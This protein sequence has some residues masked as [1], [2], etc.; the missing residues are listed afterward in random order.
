MTRE[1][2][3]EVLD[4]EGYSHEI[5][6]NKLIV[7]KAAKDSGENHN[8][9][10][11][12]I[13]SNVIF[14]VDGNLGI[15]FISSIPNGVEF[16]NTGSVIFLRLETLSPDVKFNN[17]GSI[18]MEEIEVLPSGL[19]FNNGEGIFLKMIKI[20]PEDVTF[21]NKGGLYVDVYKRGFKNW[22][23]NHEGIEGIDDLKIFRHL[24]KQGMF[25]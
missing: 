22:K 16:R 8:L 20:I 18:W 23:V 24:I 21:N 17:K 10:V 1:E 2:F 4:K 13:P 7:R 19:V 25:I 5:N 9:H 14:E 3:I 12:S 6:G 11:Y 15:G